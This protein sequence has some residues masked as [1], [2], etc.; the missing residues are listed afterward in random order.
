MFLKFV[1]F[2]MSLFAGDV[3]IYLVGG[4]FFGGGSLMS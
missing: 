4:I 1:S 2:D 3:L